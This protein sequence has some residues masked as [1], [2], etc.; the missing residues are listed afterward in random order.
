MRDGMREG[1]GKGDAGA[2]DIS[3]STRC[4]V[5]VAGG[6]NEMDG[7]NEAPTKQ[8]ITMVFMSC[9]KSWL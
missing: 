6:D 3:I 9:S 2:M 7:T 4:Y 8:D 1:A 5:F